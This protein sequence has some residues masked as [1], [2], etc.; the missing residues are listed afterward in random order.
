MFADSPQ[1]FGFEQIIGESPA[2][3]ETISLARRVASSE[4]SSVLLQG[5]SGS[6]KDC[7]A[8]AV[9]YASPRGHAPFVAIN[10]AALAPSVVASELFGH[11]QG[12][13]TGAIRARTGRF[14]PGGSSLMAPR[15]LCP[16]WINT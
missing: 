4:V 8:K 6:G 7:L 15:S 12:A 3:R 10:C 9:H 16:Y 13:F 2:M 5:E 14:E 11:E 1:T